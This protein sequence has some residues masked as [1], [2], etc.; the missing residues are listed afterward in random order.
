MQPIILPDS[1]PLAGKI[2]IAVIVVASLILFVR[3]YI[4]NRRF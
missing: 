3:G 1:F 2:V 4:R